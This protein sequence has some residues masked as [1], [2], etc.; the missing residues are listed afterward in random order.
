MAL[1][2][3]QLKRS[4]RP[5][6]SKTSP[7]WVRAARWA[8]E[9][10]DNPDA[11]APSPLACQLLAFGRKNPHKLA[12]CLA[13]LDALCHK[14]DKRKGV[15]GNPAEQKPDSEKVTANGKPKKSDS[16]SPELLPPL[17][18]ANHQ[19]KVENAGRE[20]SVR[21]PLRRIKKLFMSNKLLLDFLLGRPAPRAQALANSHAR[22]VGCKM[23]SASGGTWVMIT[24]QE[25]DEVKEG[26]PVPDL[27]PHWSL[28]S[29]RAQIAPF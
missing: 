18:I 20:A 28:A 5:K 6:G 4:G 17:G 9:N 21:Q 1:K 3:L 24:A 10:L 14:A 7:L 22:V 11:V 16:I 12:I 2:D 23:D 29:K 13:Q 26:A 27:M 15:A 8:C 19:V 25:F